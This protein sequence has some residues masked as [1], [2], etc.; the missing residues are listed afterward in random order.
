M[1]APW[2]TSQDRL[3]GGKGKREEDEAVKGGKP[4]GGRGKGCKH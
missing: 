4:R 2:L 3:E 1:R